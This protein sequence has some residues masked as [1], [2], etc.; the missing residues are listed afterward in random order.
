MHRSKDVPWKA[1]CRRS[2]STVYSA[3]W[4]WSRTTWDRIKGWE[5]QAVRRLFSFQRREDETL[6]GYLLY[7]DD[8]GGKN[9]FSI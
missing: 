9:P 1:K 8:E 7:E 5:T 4:C 6:N 2:K 3:S